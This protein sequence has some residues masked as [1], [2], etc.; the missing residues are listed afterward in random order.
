MHNRVIS[1]IFLFLFLVSCQSN[2]SESGFTFRD[3]VFQSSKFLEPSIGF[4][5]MD[6]TG[7]EIQPTEHYVY[8]PTWSNSNTI[9]F[10]DIRGGGGDPVDTPGDLVFWNAGRSMVKCWNYLAVMSFIYP[11]SISNEFIVLTSGEEIHRIRLPSIGANCK[12]IKTYVDFRA[13]GTSDIH[14]I[15]DISYSASTDTLLY[16]EIRDDKSVQK[17]IHMIMMNLTTGEVKDLGEGFNPSLSH[18]GN[19]VAFV[20][21]DGL[22]VLSVNSLEPPKRVLAYNASGYYDFE[23][24]ERSPPTPQWSFD[25]NYLLYHKCMTKPDPCSMTTDYSIFILEISSNQEIKVVDGGLYPT[26]ASGKD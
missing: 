4:V 12:I 10:Y 17:T 6:G 15:N 23:V 21:L 3:I 2:D 13:D 18:D 5:N 11:T 20:K 19:F 8:Q 14:R 26:W 1:L 22:Y 25:D 16:T 24:I 9:L 7:L